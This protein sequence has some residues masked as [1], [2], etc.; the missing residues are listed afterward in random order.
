MNLSNI[1]SITASVLGLVT[2][3][4]PTCFAAEKT[5]AEKYQERIKT[6][7]KDQTKADWIGYVPCVVPLVDETRPAQSTYIYFKNETHSKCVYETFG[8]SMAMGEGDKK[9][10]A[11]G[12]PI[13][14]KVSSYSPDFQKMLSTFISK[15]PFQV[16]YLYL[17]DSNKRKV[18][19]IWSG[20][21]ESDVR[22]EACKSLAITLAKNKAQCIK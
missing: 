14:E 10:C 18:F 6:E 17:E 11:V 19:T 15:K 22:L 5:A 12:T 7:G 1:L 13:C 2:A 3:Q 4:I 21:M 8:K 20:S 16:P 9:I